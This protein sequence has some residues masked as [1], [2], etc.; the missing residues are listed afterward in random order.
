MPAMEL[1][2]KF[3]LTLVPKAPFNFDATVHKPSHFP[4]PLEVYEKGRYWTTMEIGGRAFGVKLENFGTIAKP[5]IR[6]TFFFNGSLSEAGKH[7]LVSELNY[8]FEL[9]R[10][11]SEF[12]QTFAK[13]PLLG[14]FLKRWKGMRNSCAHNLYGLLVIGITLQNATVK[15][16][17]QMLD[18]L[19]THYGRMLFFDGKEICAFWEPE[20]MLHVPEKELKALNIGYRAKTIKKLSETFVQEKIDEKELRTLSKDEAKEKLLKLYGVGPETARILLFEALHHYDTF[21][22]VAPWQQKIYS[23]LI[24]GKK[25]VPAE[26]IKA[27]ILKRYGKYSMLAAH[28]LWEDVFWRRKHEKITWLEKEI[29]L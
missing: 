3:S 23:R 17:V 15:R 22:H 26:K 7:E 5:K 24:Y 20:E 27:D 6:V 28:Y 19:L 18:A 14:P 10:D 11:L 4:D 29:R 9:D 25:L 13:D 16:S 8:R 1:R 2:K 12:D 21:E